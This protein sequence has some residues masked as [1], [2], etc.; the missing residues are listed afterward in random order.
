MKNQ[1]NW[2]VI[3]LINRTTVYFQE[4]KIDNARLNAEQ[5]LGHV[6]QLDRIQLY[7]SFERPV[8]ADELAFYRGLVKR[9]AGYEPLQYILGKTEFMGYPFHVRPGV[10]IPRP[11]T[12]IL[13]RRD[14]KTCK[15]I[16][17]IRTQ[18]SR[19]WDWKRMHSHQPEKGIPKS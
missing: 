9:R 12:E 2:S 3:E 17:P 18:Y 19:Y 13:S 14:F 16:R 5:L 8:T 7:L 1:K 11:E 10:L 15:R 6:L 4:K